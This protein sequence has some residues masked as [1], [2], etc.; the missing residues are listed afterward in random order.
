MCY[1][2]GAPRDAC[3]G[4]VVAVERALQNLLGSVQ[5]APCSLRSIEAL[6]AALE[7]EF[8]DAGGTWDGVEAA[9][10]EKEVEKAEKE[11]RALKGASGKLAEELKNGAGLNPARWLTHALARAP[12]RL[13]HEHRVRVAQLVENVQ[14]ATNRESG[15]PAEGPDSGAL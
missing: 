4:I 10:R 15:G 6:E 13:D 1:G 12:T 14:R 9:M 5:I 3:L 2:R 8:A 11:A 7:R